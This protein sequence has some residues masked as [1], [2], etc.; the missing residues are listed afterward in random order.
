MPILEEEEKE[1]DKDKAEEE[2]EEDD[3]EAFEE[4]FAEE[5]RRDTEMGILR[6][7]DMGA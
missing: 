5:H 2:E 6:M 4:V 1:R 3:E 7:V